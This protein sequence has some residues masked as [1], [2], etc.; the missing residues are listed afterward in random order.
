MTNAELISFINQWVRNSAIDAFNDTRL[1]T[2]LLA[3]V[4]GALTNNYATYEDF[5]A[6]VTASPDAILIGFVTEDDEL[7]GDE[8]VV[9]MRVPGVGIGQL[10]FDLLTEE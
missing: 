1:N 3:L 7:T 4:N 2:V 9:L 5:A 10:A 8:N 6:A